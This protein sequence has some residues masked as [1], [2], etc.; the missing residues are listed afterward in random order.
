M[1]GPPVD[2]PPP[3]KVTELH[4][5]G[6]TEEFPEGKFGQGTIEVSGLQVDANRPG[7][8]RG[9]GPGTCGEKNP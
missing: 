8:T 5:G 2:G 6:L 1:S 9:V 4:K 3:E 7:P